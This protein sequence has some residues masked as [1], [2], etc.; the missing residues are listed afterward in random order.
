[1]HKV[2]R[3]LHH[4][5][6]RGVRLGPAGA[7]NVNELFG[8]VPELVAGG[9]PLDVMSRIGES[10]VRSSIMP[11]CFFAQAIPLHAA[12]SCCRTWLNLSLQFC[13]H[14]LKA[15]SMPSSAVSGLTGISPDPPRPIASSESI[16]AM[17]SSPLQTAGNLP[18]RT[19]LLPL[20]IRRRQAGGQR[21]KGARQLPSGWH[22]P[23]CPRL[24]AVRPR[25]PR[26]GPRTSP[27]ASSL[28]A[29]QG[30]CLFGG[31]AKLDRLFAKGR[32]HILVDCSVFRQA[33]VNL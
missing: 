12:S 18:R 16:W 4:W 32:Q 1:M 21:G 23:S 15:F 6:Q 11:G 5:R 27:L 19:R 8:H 9:L 22:S 28:P 33:K 29:C 10:S 30:L 7:V 3:G 31:K 17:A 14:F 2:C 20:K 26:A 13:P 24:C 25:R